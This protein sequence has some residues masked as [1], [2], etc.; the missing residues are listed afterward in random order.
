MAYRHVNTE[1]PFVVWRCA[2]CRALCVTD[3]RTHPLVKCG[4][5]KL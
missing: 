4:K 3:E 2:H 5:C 1:S